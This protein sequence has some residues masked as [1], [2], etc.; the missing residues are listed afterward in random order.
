MWWLILIVPALLIGHGEPL[1]TLVAYAVLFAICYGVS[2]ARHSNRRCRACG[3]SGRQKA[4]MFP[5][6]DRVCTTCGGA[7][8]HRRWGVQ[9]IY[10]DNRTR[11]ETLAARARGRRGRIR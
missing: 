10:R 3:G 8:R 6:A 5:W 11:A 4:A 7:S 1:L 9:L 2:L